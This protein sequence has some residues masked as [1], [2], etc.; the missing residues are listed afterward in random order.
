MLPFLLP[1]LQRNKE[2]GAES[3]GQWL[4]TEDSASRSYGKRWWVDASSAAF[5]SRRE[6]DGRGASACTG[7][8]RPTTYECGER[9]LGV[10]KLWRGAQATQQSSR[11]M[12]VAEVRTKRDGETWPWNSTCA[13]NGGRRRG[14]WNKEGRAGSGGNRAVEWGEGQGVLHARVKGE[15]ASRVEAC[16]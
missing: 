4:T 14:P 2:R 15:E 5:A 9:V 11:K 12:T 1:S 3:S 7:D 8:C 10:L 6:V 16:T 13:I